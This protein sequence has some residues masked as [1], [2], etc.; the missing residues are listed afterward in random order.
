VTKLVP[1]C[2]KAVPALHIPA[3]QFH[4]SINPDY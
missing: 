3:L 4:G 1:F 2:A